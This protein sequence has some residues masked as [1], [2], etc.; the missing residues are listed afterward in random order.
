MHTYKATFSRPTA[1]YNSVDD[2]C[3]G[4]S[5]LEAYKQLSKTYDA[6]DMVY[7]ISISLVEN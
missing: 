3:Y 7:L 1:K 4:Y 5:I 2:L 6:S